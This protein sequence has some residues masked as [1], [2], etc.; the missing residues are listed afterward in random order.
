MPADLKTR[1][2][3]R[4]RMFC[5]PDIGPQGMPAIPHNQDSSCWWWNLA[6]RRRQLKPGRILLAAK[7]ISCRQPEHSRG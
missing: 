1:G 4:W 7:S 2:W 6:V 3:A 5:L